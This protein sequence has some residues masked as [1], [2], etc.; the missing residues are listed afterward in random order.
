MF[1]AEWVG[2][3]RAAVTCS[4]S[5]ARFTLAYG[6]AQPLLAESWTH[7]ISGKRRDIPRAIANRVVFAYRRA[8]MSTD[9]TWR[10]FSVELGLNAHVFKF[11]N[12]TSN[13]PPHHRRERIT[14]RFKL[15]THLRRIYPSANTVLLYDLA[16]SAPYIEVRGSHIF[17]SA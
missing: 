7:P 14:L 10:A 16:G 9:R 5:A 6:L 2:A 11:G 15:T 8:R 1:Y 13:L 3:R 17:V 4:Q 12:P